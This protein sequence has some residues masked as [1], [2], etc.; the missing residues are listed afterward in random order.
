MFSLNLNL[1][2]KLPNDLLLYYG[3]VLL[4]QLCNFHFRASFICLGKNQVGS[5]VCIAKITVRVYKVCSLLP[6][7]AARIFAAMDFCPSLL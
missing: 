7:S 5:F 1:T 4:F 3:N 2:L 6:K